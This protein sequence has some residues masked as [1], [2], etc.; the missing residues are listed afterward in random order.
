MQ[1]FTSNGDVRVHIIENSWMGWKTPNKQNTMGVN[2]KIV[3]THWWVLI[4]SCRTWVDHFQPEYC[5]KHPRVKLVWVYKFKWMVIMQPHP[6]WI[7]IAQYGLDFVMIKFLA[8]LSSKLVCLSM[9]VL[10]WYKLL[11]CCWLGT[12]AHLSNVI[13][14]YIY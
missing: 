6:L 1:P 7:W 9:N 13:Q 14:Y 4:I 11:L 2:N 3:W 10:V 12:P 8:Q 5:M